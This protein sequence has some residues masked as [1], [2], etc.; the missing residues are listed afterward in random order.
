MTDSPGCRKDKLLITDGRRFV[1]HC[2]ESSTRVPPAKTFD[3]REIK[4]IFTTTSVVGTKGFHINY[5]LTALPNQG[6]EI[7]HLILTLP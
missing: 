2:G 7:L 5:N 6:K 3:S 4:F 1:P